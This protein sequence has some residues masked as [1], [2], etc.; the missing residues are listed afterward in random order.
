MIARMQGGYTPYP[1]QPLPY[2]LCKTPTQLHA[3]KHQSPQ[4]NEYRNPP[5]SDSVFDAQYLSTPVASFQSL[6]TCLTDSSFQLSSV[7]F[8]GTLLGSG[9]EATPAIDPMITTRLTVGLSKVRQ[10]T[11]F[12]HAFLK[13]R[14]THDLSALFNIPSVPFTAGSIISI[15]ELS[16]V[17]LVDR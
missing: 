14:Q 2:V 13:A 15:K 8:F 16:N 6:S 10:P 12:H 1:N 11:P 3:V 7:N 4:T 9:Y 17:C 5:F